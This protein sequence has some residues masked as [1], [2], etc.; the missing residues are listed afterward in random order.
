MSKTCVKCSYVRQ[1]TDTVPDYEC[2]HCGVI[3]AKAEAAI[4][5]KFAKVAAPDIFPEEKNNTEKKFTP[6]P[7]R[8]FRK[9]TFGLIGL[10]IFLGAGYELTRYT[11]KV[12]AESEKAERLVGFEKLKTLEKRWIDGSKLALSTSRIALS[13][14]VQN[15]QSIAR[16]LRE[17]KVSQCLAPAQAQLVEVVDLTVEAFMDFMQQHD[18]TSNLKLIEAQKKTEEYR[19]LRDKCE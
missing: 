16:E 10:V 11:Q 12:R 3:Y 2:P 1:E 9:L 8:S 4:A 19:T 18:L 14:P 17:I 15:L 7:H 5:A 13:G 6:I